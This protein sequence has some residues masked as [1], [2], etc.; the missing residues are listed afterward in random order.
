MLFVKLDFLTF[1][2]YFRLNRPSSTEPVLEVGKEVRSAS[3]VGDA[4][5]SDSEEEEFISGIFGKKT[6]GPRQQKEKRKIDRAFLH[7]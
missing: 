3:S 5:I 6:L 4:F 1:N 7:M 2:Y